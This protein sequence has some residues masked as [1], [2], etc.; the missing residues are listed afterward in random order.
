[1]N[2]T[3]AKQIC[4]IGAGA[5]GLAALKSITE[6]RQ[7]KEKLWQVVAFE[8]RDD[9]GGVWYEAVILSARVLMDF[10]SRRLPAPPSDNPPSTPM[11]DT[12]TTNLPHPVMAYASLSFPPSTYLYPPAFSVLDYLRLYASHF[13]IKKYIRFNTSIEQLDWDSS[14]NQ[15][16]IKLS[17][18]EVADFDL[19]IIASGNYRV[20]LYPSLPGLS[21][22]LSS[23][24]ASHSAWYRRPHNMGDVVLVVGAGPSRNDIAAEIHTV[25][26]TVIHSVTGGKKEDHDGLK[27]R[28]R[29]LKFMDDGQVVFEHGITEAGISHCILATGYE[30]SFP[31]INSE[32]LRLDIPPPCPPLPDTMFNS[33]Y[34][35]FPLARH[36]FP[37]Q[38]KWPPSSMAFIGLFMRTAPFPLIE[39]QCRAIIKVFENPSSLDVTQEAVDLVT[40]YEKL[41]ALHGD[42]PL[43]I[44]RHWH[45]FDGEEQWEYRDE[46][47]KLAETND[48]PRVV[49]AD[50]ER[51][52]YSEKNRLREIWQE[53]EAS[54]EADDW[55]EGVGEGGLQEWVDLTRRML[56]RTREVRSEPRL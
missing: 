3:G 41:R 34:H 43:K 44:A 8:A 54:G 25:T 23:G 21:G 5:A 6:T 56:R 37:L 45:K 19:V 50:W 51:E 42:D 46:L 24:K 53:L 10:Q 7:F 12:L 39:A 48:F 9:L 15:W 16:K 30:L 40:R 27:I 26:R 28:G 17:T 33:K 2:H 35:I 1:M 31:F 20:P 18:N 49:V 52:M 36:V 38:N 4:I 32:D 13:D 22:W 14:K 29:V 11:Y 47:Y 55:V